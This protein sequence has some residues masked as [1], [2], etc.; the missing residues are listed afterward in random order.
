MS[1]RGFCSYCKIGNRFWL[2]DDRAMRRKPMLWI[3]PRSMCSCSTS[4]LRVLLLVVS[5]IHGIKLSLLGR[6]SA[7]L[8]IGAAALLQMPIAVCLI[9]ALLTPQARPLLPPPPEI[10]FPCASSLRQQVQAQLIPS[11]SVPDQ[12]NF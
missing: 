7:N 10:I 4:M 2:A 5:R 12:Y 1:S 9:V 3:G 11:V 8:G 6:S